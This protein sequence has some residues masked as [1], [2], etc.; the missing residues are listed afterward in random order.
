MDVRWTETEMENLELANDN[1]GVV[2]KRLEGSD[3]SFRS[4][5]MDRL[6]VLASAFA[7]DYAGQALSPRATDALTTFLLGDPSFGYP[8]LT[9]TPAGDLYAEW[10]G[11]AGRA[12]TIEFLDSGDVR[13]LVF[14]P[15]PKHPQRIDRLTG[16]TTADALPDTIASLARMTGLAA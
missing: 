5:L 11:N 13:Y 15:N 14:H 10:R 3:L 2:L 8:D 12:L 4:R 6:S 1:F 9:A 7:E 16:F